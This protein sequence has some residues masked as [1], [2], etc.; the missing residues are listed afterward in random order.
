LKS[1]LAKEGCFSHFRHSMI[2]NR[3]S[4]REP[5]PFN[6]RGDL[7]ARWFRRERGTC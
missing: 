4:D 2:T 7:L 1:W 3:R 5:N 6:I